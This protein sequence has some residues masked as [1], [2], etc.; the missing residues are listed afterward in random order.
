MIVKQ[1]D[2]SAY[3]SM[4]K[5]EKNTSNNSYESLPAAHTAKNFN[6]LYK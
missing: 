2:S 1:R 5:F 6:R 3:N 4:T